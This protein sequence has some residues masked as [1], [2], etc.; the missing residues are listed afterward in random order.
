[1]SAVQANRKCGGAAG[2]LGAHS[3]TL[4]RTCGRLGV[5]PMD[6]P[7]A[8]SPARNRLLPH[9]R[10]IW[11][12][13]E[14]IR[15]NWFLGLVGFHTKG[16]P[17]ELWVYFSVRGFLL[18]SSGSA[19]A[20]YFVGAAAL[21]WFFSRNPYNQI[22][23]ADL[24]LPTRWSDLR[25]KRGQAQIEEGL[26]KLKAKQYGPA[27]MLL[28]HGLARK[29]D[30][31]AA[32]LVVGEMFTSF[33]YLSRAM[34]T[35]RGGLPYAGD[36]P[37][38]LNAAFKL[39]EYMEDYA[40]LLELVTEAEKVVPPEL[41]LL[42]RQLQE[43]RLLAYEKLGRFDEILA[44]HAAT[45]N[46]SMRLQ[47]ARLRALSGQG[48]GA[49]AI[50]ELE[51]EPAKFGLLREPW[52]LLLELA[53]ENGRADAGRKAVNELVA[54]EP[55][56]HRFYA[57]R[58]AYLVEIGAESEALDQ[59]DDYFFRFGGD[60]AASALLLKE[61]QAHPLRAVVDKAWNLCRTFGAAEPA[62]HVAYVQNLIK[63][64][65]V[66]EARRECTM[67]ARELQRRQLS[68]GGWI[69][70]TNLL[71]DSLI[72]DSPSSRNLLLNYAGARPLSPDAYRTMVGSLY[73]A[74][75]FDAARDVA[76]IGKNRYPAIQGFP[77]DVFTARSES[78]S[79]PIAV[80]AKEAPTVVSA[81]EAKPELAALEAAMQAG[82]WESA[83]AKITIVEKSPLA[84]ELGDKLLYDRITIHGHLSDQTEISWYMRRL[85]ESGRPDPARLRVIA[86]AL[87]DAGNDASAHTILREVL[88]K[89]PDAKWALTQ[90]EVWRKK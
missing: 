10:F 80:K 59:V 8:L 73:Q 75:R 64:G 42:R 5:N 83:L 58:I 53:R 2:A 70:G 78:L 35:Y 22:G 16:Y 71:L 72:L 36:Q 43:K 79:A 4:G 3:L 12:G 60:P 33:G 23:Y 19:V 87:Y 18:W 9:F 41:N 49:Q 56:R 30:N 25:A 14:A 45:P 76:Q 90:I 37:R 74:G 1:M 13:K 20:A 82:D 24:V 50:A 15:G 54:L 7:N 26:D 88:R 17:R 28:N 6:D 84:R 67:V 48:K 89:Y 11:G 77:S 32:R 65:E 31:I 57:R 55:A 52:D 40:L 66:D 51:A 44:L 27:F 61:L 81:A 38:F 69:E 63:L 86:N 85:I 68:D 46:P 47:S 62:V 29:P 21:T 39:A 34:Q